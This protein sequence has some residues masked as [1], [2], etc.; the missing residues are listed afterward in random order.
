MAACYAPDATFED[1]AFSLKGR[2]QV[3]GM[4]RGSLYGSQLSAFVEQDGNAGKLVDGR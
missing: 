3:G 4:W 1:E 2:D